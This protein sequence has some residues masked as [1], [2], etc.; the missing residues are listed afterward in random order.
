MKPKVEEYEK[1]YFRAGKHNFWEC[2]D[3]STARENITEI[4][5]WVYT[6]ILDSIHN[7]TDKPLHNIYKSIEKLPLASASF[8]KD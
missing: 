3:L 2:N 4:W 7:N 6:S 5:E 8:A 1:N